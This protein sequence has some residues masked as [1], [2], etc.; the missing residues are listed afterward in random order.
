[1]IL[2]IIDRS[3]EPPHVDEKRMVFLHIYA[4]CLKGKEIGTTSYE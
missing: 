4:T 2:R 1:M 3:R